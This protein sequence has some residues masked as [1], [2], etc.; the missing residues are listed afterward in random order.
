MRMPTGTSFVIGRQPIFDRS[1][2]VRGYEL[3][4]RTPD[5]DRP[6]AEQMTADVLLHAGLDLGLDRLVGDKAAFVNASRPFL[7]GDQEVP[8]PADKTVIE[9]LEDVA[10]DDLVVAGC[11][12][13][14]EEGFTLALDDYVWQPGDEPMLE[15]A[16]VV[17]VDVLATSEGDLAHLAELRQRYG[18]S[19]LAEKV[20]TWAQFDRCNDLGFDLFQGYLL[21]RPVAMSGRALTANQLNCLRLVETL[22]DPDTPPTDVQRIIETDPGLSM[23]FLKAAGVGARAGLN[24][25]VRSIR[26]GVVLLGQRRLR[27]W[28]MLMLLSDA[29][30][31]VPEQ[32]CI[33]MT[34]ARLSELLA[35]TAA[36]ALADSAFTVGLVSAL[37]LHLGVPLADIVPELG[38]DRELVDAV[39]GHA[40]PLGAVLA[41]VLDWEVGRRT[42]LRCGVGAAPMRRL[43]ADSVAWAGE[44]C[45]P[46]TAG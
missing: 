18:V 44:V 4:F 20:E 37:D 14:I 35:E 21:S 12:H 19:L 6:G 13:L 24:R 42:V 15:L 16:D 26:E 39:L 2:A 33:T 32:L 36:P 30:Q 43:C 46:V 41:D 17:K 25:S 34:R 22:C 9:V 40:G 10:H 29:G 38:L 11:T 31:A 8:L 27:S 5:D 1:L 7:V 3:L 45:A 28:A 23:R